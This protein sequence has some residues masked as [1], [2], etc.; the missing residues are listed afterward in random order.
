MTRIESV[1][2][3][4][5]S[6]AKETIFPKKYLP[7]II[8]NTVFLN[9]ECFKELE[10]SVVLLKKYDPITYYKLEGFG[11]NL[12]L[13]RKQYI[14]P[15]FDNDK[16]EENIVQSGAGILLNESLKDVE[17]YLEIVSKQI[18]RNV[19]KKIMD[20]IDDYLEKEVNQ[21]L[22]EL[23]EKYYEMMMDLIPPEINKPSFEEFKKSANSDEFKQM[24]E[25]QMKVAIEGR[26]SI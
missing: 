7:G 10:S 26:C 4:I 6:D 1:L 15:F 3:I 25:V 8:L 17:D 22:K 16:L 2:E 9:D 11:N 14:L 18:N 24:Q 19:Y 5:S 12:N 21:T 23:D 20:F 13:I